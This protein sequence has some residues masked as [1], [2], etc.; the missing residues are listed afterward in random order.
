[1][2][3]NFF[4]RLRNRAY[5]K[6]FLSRLFGKIKFGSRNKL[7]AISA[8][9]EN[10]RE[11]GKNRSDTEIIN[12]AERMFQLTF[13]EEEIPKENFQNNNIRT[14]SVFSPISLCNTSKVSC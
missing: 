7:L 4:I 3:R 8:D 9:N 1:M 13:S 10:Y 14:C 5:T 11:T 6:L 2:K 12:D